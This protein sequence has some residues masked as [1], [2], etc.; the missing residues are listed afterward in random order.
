MAVFEKWDCT[1]LSEFGCSLL[2]LV[3]VILF[4]YHCEVGDRIQLRTWILRYCIFVGKGPYS[5]FWAGSRVAR[6]KACGVRYQLNNCAWRPPV[7]NPY[8]KRNCPLNR[9]RGTFQLS[10]SPLIVKAVSV[11]LLQR[12]PYECAAARHVK[13]EDFQLLQFLDRYRRISEIWGNL[14][15]ALCHIVCAYYAHIGTARKLWCLYVYWRD[16][17]YGSLLVGMVFVWTKFNVVEVCLV[18]FL[19]SLVA[20]WAVRSPVNVM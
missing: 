10:R 14:F 17:L 5:L 1:L 3:R 7:A 11:A 9:P 2:P 16:I 20:Q 19:V 12:A 15:S 18:L 4:V 13:V 8:R 6:G